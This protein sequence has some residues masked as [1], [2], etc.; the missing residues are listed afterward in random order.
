MTKISERNNEEEDAQLNSARKGKSKLSLFA[1]N[2]LAINGN[3]NNN[4]N[5][6]QPTDRFEEL[7]PSSDR[8]LTDNDFPFNN[9]NNDKKDNEKKENPM[10]M[11][12][13]LIKN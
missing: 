9:K 10:D 6:Q 7:P 11:Q 13:N 1:K 2:S 5:I 8:N 4:L 3:G 12:L